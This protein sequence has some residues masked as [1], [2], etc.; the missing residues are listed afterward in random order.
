MLRPS[1]RQTHLIELTRTFARFWVRAGLAE[2]DAK[3][4]RLEYKLDVVTNA[5]T[6]QIDFGVRLRSDD[7]DLVFTCAGVLSKLGH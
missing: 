5:V 4:P 3:Q 6:G 7:L 2:G 1:I